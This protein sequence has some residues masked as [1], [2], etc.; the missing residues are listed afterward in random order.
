MEHRFPLPHSP[1]LDI[2]QGLRQTPSPRQSCHWSGQ[3]PSHG[4]ASIRVMAQSSLGVMAGPA[5]KSQ[6]QERVR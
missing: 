4:R 5:S 1:N 2:N 6:E 3:H